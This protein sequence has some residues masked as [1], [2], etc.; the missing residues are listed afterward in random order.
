LAL[1]R[2]KGRGGWQDKT[3]VSADELTDMLVG[4]LWKGDPRDVANFCVFLWERGERITLA[5]SPRMERATEAFQI[6]E[7]QCAERYASADWLIAPSISVEAGLLAAAPYMVSLKSPP[8]ADGEQAKQ[9]LHKVLGVTH[10]YL[11]PDGISKYDALNEIIGIVDTVPLVY[12][13]A[14]HLEGSEET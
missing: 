4:H 2:A 9:A 1:A 12:V 14:Q 8:T 11:L 5:D 10:R 13:E 7:A 6:A 3:L